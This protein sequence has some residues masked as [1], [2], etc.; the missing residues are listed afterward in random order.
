MQSFL[1]GPISCFP[2][3]DLRS[4]SSGGGVNAPIGTFQAYTVSTLSNESLV[5]GN[6]GGR[7]ACGVIVC[8]TKT[9]K[10]SSAV[11][12][13]VVIGILVG[14]T[15]AVASGCFFCRV[16]K[17]MPSSQTYVSAASEYEPPKLPSQEMVERAGGPHLN[18]LVHH[19]SA[20]LV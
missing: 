10:M 2:L 18:R 17:R 16:T 3:E 7:I 4:P 19:G 6:A 13:E 15:A 14:V 1:T 20:G 8:K 5:T 12:A 11:A 9:N